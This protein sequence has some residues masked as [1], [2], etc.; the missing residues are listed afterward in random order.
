M[1]K[2]QKL[3]VVI[4]AEQFVILEGI[5]PGDMFMEWPIQ[6]DEK[7]T[8]LTIPTLEGDHRADVGDWIITGIKGE[9]YPCKPDI[10]AA[11]YVEAKDFGPVFTYPV[12]GADQMRIDKIFMYHAPKEGQ[13][14]RYELLRSAGKQVAE[15]LFKL[16]PTSREQ[17]VALTK[18]Q[19]FVM[20]A[21]AAIAINEK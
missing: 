10:F 11:T 17:S 20:F 5:K 3:P 4:S 19:E 7:G 9:K 1:K 21:N 6:V 2:F 12:D 15:L 8:F 14:P 16:T 13:A 18:L